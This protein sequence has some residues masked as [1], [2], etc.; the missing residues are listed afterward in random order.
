MPRRSLAF[1]ILGLGA[2]L[3]ALGIV[4]AHGADAEA[5]PNRGVIPGRYIVVLQ[6]GTDA[7]GYTNILGRRNGF[8]ADLVYRQ[9]LRG[10]AANLSPDQVNALLADPKV[11][12]VVPDRVVR[13]VDTTPTGI[14]RID[15]EGSSPPAAGITP[16]SVS[17]SWIPASTWTTRT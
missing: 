6:E 4:F 10:F 1:S 15:A 14:D 2:A 17:P 13:A 5:P 7:A 12:N 11:N 16:A 9:A 8:S 3:F